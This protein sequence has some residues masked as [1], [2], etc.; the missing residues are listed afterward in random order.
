MKEAVLRIFY[1]D[2]SGKVNAEPQG[3]F[4]SYTGKPVF[5]ADM[6]PNKWWRNYGGYSIAKQLL[7]AFSE[8]KVKPQIIYRVKEQGTLYCTN[9]TQFLKK[10]VMVAYGGH[11][12][13]VLPI[14]YFKAVNGN[15][16]DEP[17]NLPIV[18]LNDWVKEVSEHSL[19][20]PQIEQLHFTQMSMFG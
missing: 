3:K 20:E 18:N 19:V 5:L 17:K 8:V 13:F 10:G 7:N 16:S 9:Q 15:I 6:T 12:Q 2:S 4:F 11:E 1:T 14:R